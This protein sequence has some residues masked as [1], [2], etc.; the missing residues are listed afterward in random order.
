VNDDDD[1]GDTLPMT[2]DLGGSPIVNDEPCSQ[3]MPDLGGSPTIGT[4]VCNAAL[5]DFDSP[6]MRGNVCKP[7]LHLPDFDCTSMTVSPASS[8]VSSPGD[9][10][11]PLDY[12]FAPFGHVDDDV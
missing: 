6:E 4:E 9:R 5:P 8:F 10:Q 11:V 12:F 2:A 7:S 1:D 3:L